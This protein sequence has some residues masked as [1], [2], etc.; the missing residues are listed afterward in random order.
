MAPFLNRCIRRPGIWLQPMCLFLHLMPLTRRHATALLM[1]PQRVRP[2]ARPT[3][4]TGAHT[5]CCT[6]TLWLMVVT[7]RKSWSRYHAM[8][9]AVICSENRYI[10]AV[11]SASPSGAP[12]PTP[13]YLPY[14]SP[15]PS[16]FPPHVVTP[17]V[18]WLSP[19][20]PVV[21][22]VDVVEKSVFGILFQTRQLWVELLCGAS[23]APTVA[24]PAL[25]HP[26]ASD[27]LTDTSAPGSAPA[28]IGPTDIAAVSAS[29][30]DP[31]S[32][33]SEVHDTISAAH[34]QAFISN[35]LQCCINLMHINSPRQLMT[36]AIACVRAWLQVGPLPTSSFPRP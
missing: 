21:D 8:I 19:P 25:D 29:N 2:S 22:G 31:S 35:V 17:F 3:T 36:Q 11:T 23:P 15:V 20:V 33:A 5:R 14:Q 12:H 6:S 16:F 30:A 4:A 13:P 26:A 10:W 1:F 18:S 32:V 34:A 24:A 28:T 7:R 9:K 27:G